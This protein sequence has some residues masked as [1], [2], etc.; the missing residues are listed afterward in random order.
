MDKVIK[1]L[2][3][4][5][6]KDV[7]V[8]KTICE[9][10]LLFTKRKIEDPTNLRAIMIRYLGKFVPKHG[11]TVEDKQKNYDRYLLNKSKYNN[12]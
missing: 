11:K 7:R 3:L 5:Y 1:D 10:P 2:S 9:H 6:Y 8:I 12:V 4:R